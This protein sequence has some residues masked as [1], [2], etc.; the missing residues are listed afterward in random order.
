MSDILLLH[1]SSPNSLC[2]GPRSTESPAHLI[3]CEA[4][5]IPFTD[6]ELDL[7]AWADL[8]RAWPNPPEDWTTWVDTIKVVTPETFIEEHFSGTAEFDSNR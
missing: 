1:P 4:N 6:Q 3:S 7:A 5:R 8:S 2:L